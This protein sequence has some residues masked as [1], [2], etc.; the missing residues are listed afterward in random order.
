MN[1]EAL[2]EYGQKN[3]LW[4][5]SAGFLLFNLIFCLG[6]CDTSETF[7]ALRIF[8]LFQ[9][10][11]V[12]RAR[13]VCWYIEVVGPYSDRSRSFLFSQIFRLREFVDLR[14]RHI[15][16]FHGDASPQLLKSGVIE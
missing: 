12:L 16:Y 14:R 13:L 5:F 6:I 10:D 4:H 2:I 1:L 11:F 8:R 3:Y 15:F 7:V 9:F